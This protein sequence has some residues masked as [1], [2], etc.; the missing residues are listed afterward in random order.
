[1]RFCFFVF[2]KESDAEK[3]VLIVLIS[4]VAIAVTL[5]AVIIVLMTLRSQDETSELYSMHRDLEEAQSELKEIRA[6]VEN[7]EKLVGSEG[8]YDKVCNFKYSGEQP[9][10][11]RK[12]GEVIVF[13]TPDCIHVFDKNGTDCGLFY[14]REDFTLRKTKKQSYDFIQDRILELE[15]LEDELSDYVETLQKTY[16]V[17]KK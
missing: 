16:T 7:L 8:M 9:S 2:R 11:F 13:V 14:D 10:G 5:C 15:K 12:G 6:A 4:V 3:V 17:A 1:M